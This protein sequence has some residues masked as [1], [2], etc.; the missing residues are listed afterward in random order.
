MQAVVYELNKKATEL[1]K[2][3]AMHENMDDSH[4]KNDKTLTKKRLL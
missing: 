3:S 4:T 1:C 2:M